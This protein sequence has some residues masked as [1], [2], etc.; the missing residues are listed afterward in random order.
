M[1]VG[2]V[3]LHRLMLILT[4]VGLT[5]AAD[6][7]PVTGAPPDLGQSFL[8][9]RGRLDD[10]AVPSLAAFRASLP[11]DGGGSLAG[12]HVAGRMALRVLAQPAGSPG[13]V[14]AQPDAASLFG[15][16]LAYGTTGLIAHNYLAGEAFL[17]LASGDRIVLLYADG[18][19]Q[20]YQVESVRSL[21]ALSP[22]SP[23]SQFVD[24]AAPDE[25]LSAASLF[26]Q[27]YGGTYPLVL[28]T[29]L[30]RGDNPVW[31]RWFVLAQPAIDRLA[32]GRL[33]KLA[34]LIQELG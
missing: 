18:T 32:A 29:C 20:T 10:S 27:V 8:T 6:L 19:S 12:L 21:Q 5:Q 1:I 26:G 16:A 15:M 2:T 28:Q 17:D 30:T 7:I 34:D 11:S 13:F 3:L 14:T 22:W 33:I 23:T 4:L 25:S 31:G 9:A 24:L